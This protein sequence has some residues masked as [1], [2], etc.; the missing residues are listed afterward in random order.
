MSFWIWVL[1]GLVVV[2]LI[3]AYIQHEDRELQK[4]LSDI[5]DMTNKT[6]SI[7]FP[8]SMSTQAVSRQQLSGVYSPFGSGHI[9]SAPTDPTKYDPDWTKPT[10]SERTWAL[11]TM[12]GKAEGHTIAWRAW[13]LH[14]NTPVSAVD[15]LRTDH[16]LGLSSHEAWRKL[17]D[18]YSEIEAMR[19]S[20]EPGYLLASTTFGT[21]HWKPGEPVIAE[22]IGAD[23][24]GRFSPAGPP[25]G[26]YAFKDLEQ[27]GVMQAPI[28]GQVALWGD[29]VEHERG[30]RARYAYPVK[31][32]VLG[33]E[34][35]IAEALE[36][37]YGVEVVAGEPE[38][39]SQQDMLTPL[40]RYQQAAM[41]K[42]PLLESNGNARATA[43]HR[44]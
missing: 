34:K 22:D 2:A 10:D 25:P 27:V 30:Y 38:G 26:I 9:C 35:A 16:L 44:R 28:V 32:W 20:K 12:P 17:F 42:R 21:H 31:L 33:G 18:I 36:K 37:A 7:P 4:F 13:D 40:Q 39:W 29:V 15:D 6:T 19:H 3:G 41:Q 14:R 23:I 5:H 1:I 8:P 24:D 43:E 11:S